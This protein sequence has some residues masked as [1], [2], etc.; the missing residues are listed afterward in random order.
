[1]NTSSNREGKIFRLLSASEKLPS[2][3]ARPFMNAT[4]SSRGFAANVARSRK[5]RVE[6]GN[7]LKKACVGMDAAVGRGDEVRVMR[8]IRRP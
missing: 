5:L 2:T 4:F 8:T 3:P 7:A 6:M 1:M